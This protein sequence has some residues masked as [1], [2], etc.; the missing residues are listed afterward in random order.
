M[1]VGPQHHVCRGPNHPKDLITPMSHGPWLPTSP[2]PKLPSGPQSPLR[3]HPPY[4]IGP[5]HFGP[6]LHLWAES[7]LHTS[8]SHLK[9]LDRTKKVTFDSSFWQIHW[10]RRCSLKTVDLWWPSH[11]TLIKIF[12]FID[13][14]DSLALMICWFKIRVWQ[15]VLHSYLDD[16]A[17]WGFLSQICLRLP[18]LRDLFHRKEIGCDSTRV[19]LMISHV[20]L[21][22]GAI[23]LKVWSILVKHLL[24]L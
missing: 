9:T 11:V 6:N 10:H 21:F 12:W 8:T 17:L 24:H 20:S 3:R 22:K 2:C 15:L 19:F 18:T 14:N 16:L 13:L 23:E 5:N 7:Y 4:W 1:V